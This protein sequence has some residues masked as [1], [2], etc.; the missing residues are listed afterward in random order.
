M[1]GG[2][3]LRSR[4]AHNRKAKDGD[5]MMQHEPTESNAWAD[6]MIGL[7]GHMLTTA[8]DRGAAL[9]V[10]VNVMGLFVV[11]VIRTSPSADPDRVI[12]DIV[13][14]VRAAIKQNL[15]LCAPDGER[16]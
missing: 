3:I 8:P 1:R 16:H 4:L 14:G 13:T 10:L 6:E 7:M 15:H 9:T 11:N 2:N 5:T 12:A